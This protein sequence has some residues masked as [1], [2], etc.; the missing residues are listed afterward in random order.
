MK[1]ILIVFIVLLVL[2]LIMSS[3]GGSIRVQEN[4]EDDMPLYEERIMPS[5]SKPWA[6]NPNF[7][8]EES[9]YKPPPRI[10]ANSLKQK[11]NK[12]VE[13]PTKRDDVFDKMD[14]EELPVDEED[15]SPFATDGDFAPV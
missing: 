1:E 11:Q 13:T 10:Y 9:T 3:L 4:F 6:M 7:I 2:L 14:E 8:P 12:A 5:D 15:V